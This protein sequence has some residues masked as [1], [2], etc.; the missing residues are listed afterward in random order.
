MKA[1]FAACVLLLVVLSGCSRQSGTPAVAIRH[2]AD[3][4]P[5]LSQTDCF[6]T[7]PTYDAWM[8]RIRARNAWWKPKLLLLPLMFPRADFE[9]GQQQLDC[10]AITYENDGLTISGWMVV[11][12]GK[13]GSRFPVLIYNRGG[14]GSFGALD[15]A[16]LMSNVFPYAEHGFIVLASQYRGVPE[17]DPKRFGVDHFGGDDVRD[18]TRLIEL[19]KRL[20]N[21]D[22]HDIFMLGVSR[23]GM[24]SFMA[25]RHSRDIKAMAVIS[26][27]S[28]LES[29][30]QFRPEMEQVYLER[31]PGY[32]SAK[33]SALAKRSVLAWAQDLPEDMPVLLLHG[34]KDERVSVANGIRLHQ[35]LDQLQRPNRLI[36]YPGDDHFLS[37]HRKEAIE[38]IVRWF[39]A[40]MPT[41][42]AAATAA[43]KGN[44][45]N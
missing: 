37:H 44:V 26:G 38:E 34:D 25:A 27:V 1:L 2:I 18:V 33:A 35:R 29:E 3:P 11:P 6:A 17:T 7:W 9:R 4:A 10:S 12:K 15:F 22:P 24:M 5:F 20:P 16:L 21:A 42:G 23:G 28:D 19:A 30:L 14:N 40:A 8:D 39:R 13:P 45:A 32:R 41:E 36:V 31:I 43:T